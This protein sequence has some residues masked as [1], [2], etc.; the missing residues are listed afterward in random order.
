MKIKNIIM[1]LASFAS[2]SLLVSSINSSAIIPPEDAIDQY[3]TEYFDV[4][5]K[6]T[7]T[8]E[9]TIKQ[10][11][12][13]LT[14][15]AKNAGVTE[16]STPGYLG[17]NHTTTQIASAEATPNQIVGSDGRKR[18]PEPWKSSPYKAICRIVTYWDINE[19]GK[20]DSEV[21][22]GTGFLE[23]PSAVVTNGHVIYDPDHDMWCKYAEVTF[24]QDGEDSAYFGTQRS[25]TIHT[26]AA[27]IENASVNQDWALIEINSAIGNR[28]G[29]FGKLWTSGT[30]TGRS[31]T[32]T[33]YPGDKPQTM[34]KSTGSIK[35]T[36]TR[37]VKHN[38]DTVGGQSG[39]PIYNS[40]NQVLAIHSGWV[41]SYNRGVR[42]TEWLYN[43]LE[44][45]N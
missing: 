36:Q 23:G 5:S 21:G 45:Y 38:C 28:T 19:D 14:T 18:V 39:S 37:I 26:S 13:Q 1:L 25:T 35:E 34:W 27:W 2:L 24:A 22:V 9:I 8:E 43:F 6:N 42:I 17:N 44:D 10:Y 31:V 33:G 16:L 20:I 41:G 30:L 4:V 32:V 29:W 40:D 12:T 15:Q 3:Q 7:L 11:D